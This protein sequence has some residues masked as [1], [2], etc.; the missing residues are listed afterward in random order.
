[1]H[2]YHSCT[3]LNDCKLFPIKCMFSFKNI[4]RTAYSTY[5]TH[6]NTKTAVESNSVQIWSFVIFVNIFYSSIC[7]IEVMSDRESNSVSRFSFLSLYISVNGKK[8]FLYKSVK[9]WYTYLTKRAHMECSV[10][11]NNLNCY[12][13]YLI[14]ICVY[15]DT[16]LFHKQSFNRTDRVKAEV[17]RTQFFIGIL[18]DRVEGKGLQEAVLYWN[19]NRK[20]WKQQF[21]GIRHSRWTA[22]QK[23]IPWTLSICWQNFF[24][25]HV[26]LIS[27]VVYEQIKNYITF[28]FW[29]SLSQHAE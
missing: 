9:R 27:A 23:Y 20:G 1:M 24:L 22:L 6:T 7:Q 29:A 13:S 8:Q 4:N 12:G 14:A 3:C 18:T 21:T 15:A 5:T 10:L 17:H 26:K 25:L 28:N 2:K 11:I 19:I 16:V